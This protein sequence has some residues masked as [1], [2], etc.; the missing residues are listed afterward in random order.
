MA[1]DTRVTVPAVYTD[2]IRAWDP[3]EALLVVNRIPDAGETGVPWDPD[4]RFQ[5][6]CTTGSPLAADTQ[7]WVLRGSTGTTVLAVDMAA[8]GVQPGYSGSA[9]YRQSVGSA[10][11]DELDVAIAPDIAFESMEVV[12]IRITAAIGG[13]PSETTNYEFT[14]AD[15][16]HPEITEI[17]WLSATRALVRLDEVAHDDSLYLLYAKGNVDIQGSGHVIVRGASDEATSISAGMALEVRGSGAT[18]NNMSGFVITA[19]GSGNSGAPGYLDLAGDESNTVEDTGVDRDS[20]GIIEDQRDLRCSIARIVLTARLSSEGATAESYAAERIQTSY[21]PL[22]RQISKVASEDLAEGLAYGQWLYVDFDEP[23]SLGRLYTLAWTLGDTLG[24]WGESTYMFQ[25]PRFG[26]EEGIDFWANGIQSS[27]DKEA[28]LREGTGA[29]R[30]LSVIL[31]DALLLQRYYAQQMVHL[32]DAGKCPDAWVPFLLYD[33]GNPF[34]FAT[35][36]LRLGRR[37]AEFLPDLLRAKGTAGAIEV[38]IARVLG[39]QGSAVA[40]WTADNWV[41]GSPV[42]GRLG[43]TTV[44]CPSTAY[45][46]NCW[47]FYSARDVTD[48]EESIIVEICRWADPF[49]LHFL[50]VIEP[51][52]VQDGSL[53]PGGGYWVL[54][55]SVLG[56]STILSP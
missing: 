54:G 24:N 35:Q 32:D 3:A 25:M 23:L 18:V 33:R 30:R 20:Q 51:S 22:V 55:T 5:V 8:G 19:T 44:L 52:D 6:V 14:V 7:V 27:R 38:F 29:L 10:V 26:V 53:V 2:E 40:Y 15:Y 41:L 34:T 21:V 43:H 46:R 50:G 42:L 48:A 16:N 49:N 28:D 12:G 37:V 56:S 11:L 39:I 9:A 31:G 4:I 45:E 13:Q 47:V 36:S 1:D 17:V